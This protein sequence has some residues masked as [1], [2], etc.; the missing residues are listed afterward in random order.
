M[1]Q[2]Q[3]GTFLSPPTVKRHI[4]LTENEMK[5]IVSRKKNLWN[6]FCRHMRTRKLDELICKSFSK[7]KLVGMVKRHCQ[8]LSGQYLV[9]GVRGEVSNC[10]IQVFDVNK[11][12]GSV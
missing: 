8:S 4:N 12:L 6:C 7:M 5:D 1:S 3:R 2:S 10:Q 9:F 11:Q